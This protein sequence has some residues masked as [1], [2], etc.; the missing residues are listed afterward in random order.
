MDT[1]INIPQPAWIL[2]TGAGAGLGEAMARRF[3]E[4][5]HRLILT[6]VALD[7]VQA[8]A[9]E[10]GERAHAYALDVTQA[11]QWAAL[12]EQVERQ[13][14]PIDVLINNA[15]VAVAGSMEDTS[16]EDWRWVIEIDLMGVVMGCK[17]VLPAMRARGRGHLINVASFAGLAGAPEINAYGTAKAGVVALSEGLRAE[18]DG[19]GVAVSV[20]CPAFV[21]TRLLETMRASDDKYQRRVSRWMANSG[22]SAADVA[23]V[24]YGA[25]QSRRFLLLTHRST[26][27]LWR[28]KRWL[29]AL[30][31][32]LLVRGA[33]RAR[34]SRGR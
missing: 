9:A 20:L 15:G 23:D 24:V 10:L 29:P 11:D 30:Y 1:S 3:Y 25:L 18:L 26:H 7:R 13:H 31:F 6:D 27:W 34:A 33:R 32:Q 16:L 2:I 5:G 14:G 28:L 12:V 21:Q 22:V 4:A 17:A 19:S 8:L